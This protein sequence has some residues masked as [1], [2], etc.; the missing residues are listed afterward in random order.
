MNFEYHYTESDA[1]RKA[2]WATIGVLDAK[3]LGSV[4]SI[5]E[6]GDSRPCWPSYRQAFLLIDTPKGS[7]LVS[8]GLSDPYADFDKNTEVQNFNGVG[9]EIYIESTQRFENIQQAAKSWEFHLL[10]QAAQFVANNPKVMAHLNEH[11]Y[12]S[13]QLYNCPLPE[14]FK[15][16]NGSVGA[17][18]GLPSA[19]VATNL[20][21]TIETIRLINLTLITQQELKWVIAQGGVEEGDK[22]VECLKCFQG[23]SPLERPSVIS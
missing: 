5:I 14:Y 23:K 4:T 6:Q 22:L 1:L 15:D 7:I 17:L 8:E 3:V 21:L 18:L 9:F 16:E 19:T 2:Y 10:Y 11:Q 12:L 13:T 20:R